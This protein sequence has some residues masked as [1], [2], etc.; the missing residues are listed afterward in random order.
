MV[1][2]KIEIHCYLWK[3]RFFRTHPEKL[4]LAKLETVPQKMSLLGLSN[5]ECPAKNLFKVTHHV[6]ATMGLN[7]KDPKYLRTLSFIY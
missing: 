1:R 4:C 2:V 3:Q 6:L 5:L 7:F